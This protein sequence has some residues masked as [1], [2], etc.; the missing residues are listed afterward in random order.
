MVD[1][2]KPPQTFE[3]FEEAE[4][5][6]F[7]QPGLS[8][9][10]ID[11]KIDK[12][13][14]L[15]ESYGDNLSSFRNF[16]ERTAASATF[17][18][19][20]YALV[21]AFGPKMK[22]ALRERKRLNPKTKILGDVAGIAGPLFLSGGSSLFAKGAQLGGAGVV[23]AAKGATAL[24]KLTAKGL[25][26]LVGDRI[27]KKLAKDVLIKGVS[28]GAGSAVEGALYS[29]GQLISEAAL[30]EKEYN[31]ENVLAAGKEG[32]L[33]GGIVGAGFGMAPSLFKGATE[34]VVPKIKNNKIVGYVSKKVDNWKEDYVDPN[35]NAYKMAG[36]DDVSYYE[37]NK[38]KPDQVKNTPK[39]LR[40][41]AKQEGYGVFD[42]PIKLYEGIDKY[43][44][45][46]NKKINKVL[47]AIDDVDESLGD[48][49]PT[50]SSVALK[51]DAALNKLQTEDYI[52]E[53]GYLVKT[54]KGG[55]NFN[56]IQKI[57]DSLDDVILDESKLT[58]K[59]LYALKKKYDKAIN[60][61]KNKL[62]GQDLAD[63]ALADVIRR[64][65]YDLAEK[66]PGALGPRLRK[67]MLDYA[68]LSTF[69]RPFKQHLKK[70]PQ[71]GWG[72]WKDLFMGSVAGSLF[73]ASGVIG[74]G[75]AIKAYSKSDL[76]NRISV[77]TGIEAS[78]QGVSKN[79]KKAAKGFLSKKNFTEKL[80]PVSRRVLTASPLAFKD[81]ERPKDEQQALQNISSNLDEL[82][83]DS[84]KLKAISK[85]EQMNVVAPQ[86]FGQMKTVAARA[87]VFL[88]SK[89][90]RMFS[91]NPLLQKKL[92]PSSQ[93]LYKFKKYMEAIQDPM[94]VFKEFS[95]GKISR[96]SI[97]AI[98]FVY[99]DIY[100]RMRVEVMQSV[101]KDPDSIDYKQ[102]LLLGIL[103][104]APTD[105]ALLPD[106]I[107][108][109]QQYYSESAVSKSG[110]KIPVT[111]AKEIDK[112]ESTATQLEKLQN[113][114]RFS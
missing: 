22:D 11:T 3:E 92:R 71:E 5:T 80:E 59:G 81:G 23:G 46:V 74:A 104:N 86:T 21:K 82:K 38:F 48:I 90:P 12:E 98:S 85:N 109:L 36:V 27:K 88:D 8:Q 34:I 18:L 32:A 94:K 47:S 40:D 51:M 77:L 4:A 31:A 50:R 89:I 97:E 95:K 68:T 107:K 15:R 53:F 7:R 49:F 2:T 91:V 87:L 78:N 29:Q 33:W 9:E 16:L 55:T 6:E 103:L 25:Q 83:S 57:R 10:D 37:L 19:S 61:D 28:K 76:H 43:K 75:M 24:E 108:A 26:N 56:A 63:L 39:V 17:G 111:A 41:V 72:F 45:K 35:R 20:D 62:S 110:G 64:E 105:L 106:S 113:P 84:S 114:E 67:E 69:Q 60:F 65:V 66:A 13:I 54:S 44:V 100:A 93:E 30:G 42:K 96:E 101:E 112:A 70:T 99:P 1:E 52:D 58:A 102:R 79:I 14:E 73:D